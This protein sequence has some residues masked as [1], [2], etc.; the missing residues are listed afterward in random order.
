MADSRET[1]L[2][3]L[4]KARQPF[5]D[6]PAAPEEYIPMVPMAETDQATLTKR[7]VEEAEK[8]A[9]IVHQV[10]TPSAAINTIL[11]IV[12]DDSSI[13]RWDDEHLPLPDFSSALEQA[14]IGTANPNDPEIRV[15]I[16]GVDAALAATGSL[17]VASGPGKYRNASLLAPVHIAVVST[18]QIIPGM[19]SWVAA[20][21]ADDLTT[22]RNSSNIVI[23][24]GA[25]RTADI[26][27]ELILGMHGPGELYIVLVDGQSSH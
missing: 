9:A 8:L 14:G 23:I 24:S 26:A 13:I 3:K 16:S 25:S 11:E 7:F 4:R 5:A 17:V 20:Q 21:S 2:G 18:D 1:I 12:G 22:L 19:E 15:G 27:M 6:A 10:S